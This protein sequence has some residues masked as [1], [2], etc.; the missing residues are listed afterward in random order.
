MSAVVIRKLRPA[1]CMGEKSGTVG[2]ASKGELTTAADQV[3]DRL[4]QVKTRA[5]AVGGVPW[6]RE[7][8]RPTH[9][10]LRAMFVEQHANVRLCRESCVR[11][12]VDD[13]ELGS[14]LGWTGGYFPSKQKLLASAFTAA[15]D[16]SG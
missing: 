7:S 10:P 12:R 13:S 4:D 5:G 6:R 15:G 9:M 11:G 3:D 8:N 16:S 2:D 1:N 14:C